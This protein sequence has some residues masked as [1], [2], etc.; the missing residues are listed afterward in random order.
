MAT[1]ATERKAKARR[2]PAQGQRV[3]ELLLQSSA[4]TPDQV[5]TM[6]GTTPNGLPEPEVRR[7]RDHYGSNQVARDRPQTWYAMLLANF[8]NPFILVL[9]GIGAVSLLSFDWITRAWTPDW[10]T[11]TVVSV[12]VTVSVLMR[13]LQEYRSSRAAEQLRAMVRTKASVTRQYVVAT[14]DGGHEFVPRKEEVPF[15]DLVPG[16]VIF[17]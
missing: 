5:L 8:K 17:L 4:G 16:D 14:G 1:L 7:R 11:F 10:K 15:E 6:L 13:F 3:S 2:K 12:M 9:V